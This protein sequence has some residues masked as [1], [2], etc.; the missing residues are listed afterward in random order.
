MDLYTITT[1]ENLDR[2]ARNCPRALSAFIHL[3]CNAKDNG[4]VILQKRQ[5]SD[6]MSESFTKFRNDLR[7]LARENLL[8]WHQMNDTI[9]VTL[10]LPESF[11]DGK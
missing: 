10:A 1:H 3:L 2:I 5:I 6:A 8:E 9:H 4:S 7:S 11:E